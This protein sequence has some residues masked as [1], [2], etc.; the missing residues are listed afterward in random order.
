MAACTS[1]AKPGSGAGAS[2][3]FSRGALVGL[4]KKGPQLRLE[5]RRVFKSDDPLPQYPRAVIKHRGRQSLNAAKLPP[6]II[7]R[8]RQG[9]VDTDRFRKLNRILR[10]LH[11]VELESDD[12]EPA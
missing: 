3:N 8:G 12:G 7:G 9:I 4:L 10:I 1:L 11:D 6:Q 2:P 5:H